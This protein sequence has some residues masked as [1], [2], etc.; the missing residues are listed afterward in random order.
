[1]NDYSTSTKNSNK[2]KEKSY[3]RDF[4]YTIPSKIFHDESL[5][6]NDVKVYMMIRSF[7]DTTGDAYPSNN[8]ISR[9]LNMHRVTVIRCINHLIER[10]YIVKEEIN[11]VRHLRTNSAPLPVK[12]IEE[13]D[14]DKN[15]NN[16]D[17]S[18]PQ[19]VAPVLPPSSTAATPPS[20][21]SATQLDQNTI[22]SKIIKK[23]F[24]TKVVDNFFKAP[25]EQEQKANLEDR[26]RKGI[27][28]LRKLKGAF[29]DYFNIPTGLLGDR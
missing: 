14:G 26:K 12:V 27:H 22:T 15:S 10:G 6:F 4:I 18:Y 28:E 2:N 24:S 25:T 1:M 17:G 29:S 16:N 19:V 20:S 8:W 13:D 3:N 7:M 21:A 23:D 5:T 9:E 11:G